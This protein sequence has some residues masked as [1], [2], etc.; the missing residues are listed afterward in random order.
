MLFILDSMLKIYNIKFETPNMEFKMTF[1]EEI[2]RI[3]EKSQPAF[4]AFAAADD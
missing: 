4:A 2:G 1:R 3:T